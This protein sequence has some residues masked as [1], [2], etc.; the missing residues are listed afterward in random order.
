[1]LGYCVYCCFCM[2]K[3]LGH[4]WGFVSCL[5][6]LLP[7]LALKFSPPPQFHPVFVFITICP[8]HRTTL[9]RGTR[10]LP[11]L[12]PP[13]SLPSLPMLFSNFLPSSTPPH[14]STP[15]LLISQSSQSQSRGYAKPWLAHSKTPTPTKC[16]SC[17][18]HG[19]TP[20]HEVTHCLPSPK[21][22]NTLT[23]SLKRKCV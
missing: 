21:S 2:S 12:S 8:I 3:S 18:E 6:I 4:L 7:F 11:H 23:K 14:N 16:Q 1:M 20:G 10:S 22:P 17:P 13:V 9:C 5:F 15:C 19:H